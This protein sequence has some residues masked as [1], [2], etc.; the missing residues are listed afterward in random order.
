[1][2]DPSKDPDYDSC[3]GAVRTDP[4]LRNISPVSFS[5]KVRR[6]IWSMVQ[7][8]VYRYSFHTQSAWRAFLLRCFG[9]K[10]G[11]QCTVRR[12]SRVY[13]PWLLE[14]GDLAC[15]GDDCTVYNLGKITIGTRASISQEAYLC[16]GT[17]DY[18]DISLP[19]IT[20]P[21]TIGADVWICARAFIGPGRTVGEGAVVAAC[22]VVVRDVPPWT[23]VG[24]NPAKPIGHRELRGR[25]V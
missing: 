2:A 24:G 12:T 5:W 6:L 19:L 1:M 16:A 11:R 22:A 21:V 13:Y 3:A 23:I 4:A 14:L 25:N 7:G 10:I 15:L 9:A 8:T 18:R 17:H 20:A